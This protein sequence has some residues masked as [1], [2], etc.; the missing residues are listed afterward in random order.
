MVLT[1]SLVLLE[2]LLEE[3]GYVPVEDGCYLVVD[4]DLHSGGFVEVY[5]HVHTRD[6]VDVF[7]P[8]D[9]LA[10]GGVEVALLAVALVLD[11]VLLEDVEDV[12]HLVDDALGVG[13]LALQLDGQL[14]VVVLA[15]VGLDQLPGLVGLSLDDLDQRV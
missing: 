10:R 11:H 3:V 12:A 15:L 9:S 1:D 7:S 2:F 8:A 13:L 14:Q 5:V 4:V 6:Y